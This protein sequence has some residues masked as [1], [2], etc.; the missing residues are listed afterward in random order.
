VH[1]KIKHELPGASGKLRC[2][3]KSFKKHIGFR[4]K[5]PSLEAPKCASDVIQKK[6]VAYLDPVPYCNFSLCF[7]HLDAFD[8]HSRGVDVQ[9]TPHWKSNVEIKQS[10]SHMHWTLSWKPHTS[11]TCL[12]AQG[13]QLK[14]FQVFCNKTYRSWHHEHLLT[15]SIAHPILTSNPSKALVVHLHSGEVKKQGSKCQILSTEALSATVESNY[16]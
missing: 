5:V 6:K 7:E 2:L 11:Q 9:Q 4:R 12:Q 3:N 15:K 10:R 13:T 14:R 16:N 8:K 1:S